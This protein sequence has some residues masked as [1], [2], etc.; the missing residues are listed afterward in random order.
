M[1]RYRPRIRHVGEAFAQLFNKCGLVWFLRSNEGD[2]ALKCLLSKLWCVV[3]PPTRIGD[4][5]GPLAVGWSLL[6]AHRYYTLTGSYKYR[7][8]P[9]SDGLVNVYHFTELDKGREG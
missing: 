4:A 8:V 5:Y 6:H 2:R 3:L 7:M 9:G 1:E